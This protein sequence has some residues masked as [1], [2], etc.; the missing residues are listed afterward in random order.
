MEKNEIC[1]KIVP[2][3]GFELST[4]QEGRHC[5]ESKPGLL[6][7]GPICQPLHSIYLFMASPHA[8]YSYVTY[9]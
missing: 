9:K 4:C 5:Q 6:I 8:Q 2:L 3:M 1:R 7:A